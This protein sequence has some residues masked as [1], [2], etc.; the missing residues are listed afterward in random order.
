MAL[1]SS[2]K[3]AARHKKTLCVDRLRLFNRKSLPFLFRSRKKTG[4]A[5]AGKFPITR[6][7]RSVLG[8]VFVYTLNRLIR[9]GRQ[10][11]ENREIASGG[12]SATL[13]KA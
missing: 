3:R 6:S 8:L 1:H 13:E 5:L 9:K 7:H 11:R 10:S 4:P 2:K 12:K